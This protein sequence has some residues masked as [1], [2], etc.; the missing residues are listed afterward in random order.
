V[1]AVLACFSITGKKN[2]F[3][4][5]FFLF[6]ISVT[7]LFWLDWNVLWLGSLFLSLYL[8]YEIIGEVQAIFA[9]KEVNE[10][11]LTRD[12]DL[13]KTRFET[14]REK[15]DSDKEVFETEI[16][17]QESA[18]KEKGAEMDS[19]RVLIGISHKETRRLEEIVYELKQS[20]GNQQDALNYRQTI[21]KSLQTKKS[22]KQPISLKDLMK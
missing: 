5:G 9:K 15:I 7:Y 16:L 1:L 6:M 4:A 20:I 21:N 3:L 14:L 8:G 10:M 17:K 18:V 2:L 22:I 13:W 11:G 12:V 19:L